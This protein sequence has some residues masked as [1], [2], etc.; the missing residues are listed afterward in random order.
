MDVTG[1]GEADPVADNDIESGRACNRRVT[2]TIV[3]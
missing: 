2:V 1:C 3:R